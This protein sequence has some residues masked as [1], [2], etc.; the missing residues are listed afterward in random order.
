MNLRENELES[1][2]RTAQSACRV[3]VQR[4]CSTMHA[5]SV[6]WP[7]EGRAKPGMCVEVRRPTQG[8]ARG[9]RRVSPTSMRS[10]M[11]GRC[12]GYICGS[13]P[14]ISVR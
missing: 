5:K 13:R 2:A 9:C 7:S 4:E 6:R 3:D 10:A 14:E 1:E 8:L 12:D 11:P